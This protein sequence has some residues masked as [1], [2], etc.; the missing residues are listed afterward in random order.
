MSLHSRLYKAL[1]L[2]VVYIGIALLGMVRAADAKDVHALLII[3]GNDRK[4]RDSVQENESQMVKMLRQLSRDCTVHLTVMKSESDYQGVISE[5]TFVDG[6]GGTPKTTAQDM[7]RSHQV[8]EWVGGL[9]PQPDDTVLIY[10]SGHG[11]IGTFNRHFL[12]FDLG[13]GAD[14]LDRQALSENLKDKPARLRMLITDT[15]SNLSQDLS[16]D[17]YVKYAVGVRERARQNHTSALFLEHE[18]FLDIT[19]ASPGQIAIGNN[20]L[21]GHFTSALLSQ[22]FTAVSDTDRDGFLS[23]QEVFDKSVVQTNKLY[24]EATFNAG[25]VSELQ[26]NRQTTQDPLAY[27][28]PTRI[29]G[30]DG[31][32]T[33]TQPPTPTGAVAVLNFTSV[34]SGAKVSIDGFI[35]G[36]TPL[37]G[38]ELETD[39]SSTKDIEV[40]VKAE[41]YAEAVE[42]FKVRRGHPFSW[43]FTLMKAVPK[44]FTGRDGAEMVL[45]PA[46]E[47]QMGSNGPEAS[48]D[49]QPVH[50]V[51]VDAFYMDRY[52]V[53]NAQYKRFVDAN[54]SWGK[55]RIDM[56]FCNGFYLNDWNGNDYPDGKANHPVKNVGWY[57]AMAYAK[58]AGKRLPTEAEWEYAARGGLSGKKY[59]WGDVFDSDKADYTESI[60]Q[61]SETKPVGNFPPNGYGLYDMAG[62][63][64]EWC[65]DEYDE[66]FYSRSPRRNPFPGA[67]SV[68][69]VIRNFT[70]VN[71]NTSC[72]LRGGSWLDDPENLRVATRYRASRFFSALTYGF[73]CVK[74]Q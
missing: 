38:Y 61:M 54:P 12:R 10:Y 67:D 14:M 58:W 20:D 48:D 72:V 19:A 65:L 44:T 21:G 46:G 43:E 39:G 8:A 13:E 28:L 40:T 47:F 68:D 56:R 30:G 66:G 70:N 26:K 16:D 29:G 34:P 49:E 53:T 37:K 6:T 41:G 50:T 63:V 1:P 64:Q 25:I 23:W 5:T 15:C 7:I 24:E 32:R 22:G 27:S 42:K 17:V 55:G 2:L 62:N 11:E 35:V 51:Y 4:I 9:K 71:R 45:I 73:R 31:G 60:L 36:Q 33:P 18:G 69:W 52:E 57:E 74:A 59:P 3:L